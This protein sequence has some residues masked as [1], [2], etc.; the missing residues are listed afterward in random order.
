MQLKLAEIC[1]PRVRE[2]N[3]ARNAIWQGCP[4]E[5]A[6][7]AAPEDRSGYSILYLPTNADD[8]EMRLIEVNELVADRNDD[9]LEPI[10]FGVDRGMEPEHQLF[11]LD[12]TPNQWDRIRQ[13]LLPLPGNWSLD[14][15]EY[16]GP[17][18]NE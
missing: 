4:G 17:D 10:N 3:H 9:T 7:Q 5:L 13:S 11:V 18:R 8:R 14:H 1:L 16:F 2:V 12:V 6:R 15:A